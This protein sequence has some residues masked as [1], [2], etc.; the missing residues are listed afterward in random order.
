M[1]INSINQFKKMNKNASTEKLAL[2]KKVAV[3]GHNIFDEI[4]ETCKVCTLEQISEALYDMV[5]RY[6][7][8]M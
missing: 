6:R 8:N 3:S 1:A 2:L 4:M 7:R 5:G